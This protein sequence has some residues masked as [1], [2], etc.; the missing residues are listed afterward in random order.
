MSEIR[1]I[2]SLADCLLGKKTSAYNLLHNKNGEAAEIAR[3][4]RNA[5]T[6]YTGDAPLV[7]EQINTID[8][9]LDD[10]AS[11]V[12]P[13]RRGHEKSMVPQNEQDEIRRQLEVNLGYMRSAISNDLWKGLNMQ[14]TGSVPFEVDIP[15]EIAESWADAHDEDIKLVGGDALLKLRSHNFHG[16]RCFCN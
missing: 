14:G 10:P 4:L 9:W 16:T 7:E 13:A 3:K 6:W 5:C 2:S 15:G 8:T 11:F 12:I 1:S